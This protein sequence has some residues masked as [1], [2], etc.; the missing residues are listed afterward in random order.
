MK[1]L[2]SLFLALVLLT[3]QF[4]MVFAATSTTNASTEESK[5]LSKTTFINHRTSDGHWKSCII[6]LMG[7]RQ[8]Y[9]TSP[10]EY[11]FAVTVDIILD[12]FVGTP[13]AT[14]ANNFPISKF[15]NDKISIDFKELNNPLL[16]DNGPSIMRAP[17][18]G[19]NCNLVLSESTKLNISGEMIISTPV[20]KTGIT[21]PMTLSDNINLFMQM[22]TAKLTDLSLYT[23]IAAKPYG[24]DKIGKF[25][26]RLDLI[27]DATYINLDNSK[28]YVLRDLPS[29]EKLTFNVSTHFYD[30]KIDSNT[31]KSFVESKGK[32]E[33][34]SMEELRL[35]VYSLKAYKNLDQYE[36]YYFYDCGKFYRQI[37]INSKVK[38]ETVL[39]QIVDTFSYDNNLITTKFDYW[40]YKSASASNHYYLSSGSA[41]RFKSALKLYTKSEN[42]KVNGSE[43]K[44]VHFITEDQNFYMT[45]STYSSKDTLDTQKTALIKALKNDYPKYIYKY[46]ELVNGQF[47][48]LIGKKNGKLSSIVLVK[49]DGNKIEE[50]RLFIND[51]KYLPSIK[52]IVAS[53]IGEYKYKADLNKK[54]F[55]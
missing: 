5:P 16:G 32:D 48:A 34:L 37:T 53:I 51:E 47:Y 8:I 42:L 27:E 31:L 33:K 23:N 30:D 9:S 39:N 2:I 1:K 13:N 18:K 25:T 40:G 35:G 4:S 52:E 44:T 6:Q 29:S 17:Y 43:A 49:K 26:T 7:A 10:K 12:G 46:A 20:D 15:G 38:F 50:I 36:A 54:I 41:T 24:N 22:N 55:K 11:R 45:Q 28:Q 3:S 14:L 21:I 19:E